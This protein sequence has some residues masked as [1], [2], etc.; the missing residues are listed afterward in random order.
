VARMIPP[1]VPEECRSPGE[2]EIFARLQDDPATSD[3][4]VLH[5]LDVA[6]H[7]R[8]VAGEIDFVIVVPEKGVLCLEV[9]ACRELHRQGGLWYY[10]P[11]SSTE[12][13]ARGPFRQVADT[14]HSLR[15]RLVKRAPGLANVVFWSGVVFPYVNF[16]VS[17]E[18]WHE[19]QV[20]DA[21]LFKSHPFALLV[22]NMLDRAREHLVNAETAKWFDARSRSPDSLQAETL[23]QMLRPHFEFFQSPKARIQQLDDE[24]NRYT[25]EQLEAL[26]A[27]EANS[28]VLFEGPAGTGK[29]MLAIE[30][31]RRGAA[32]GRRV[33]FVCFNRLLAR[34]L[35]VDIASMPSVKVCT[36]HRHML[37]VVGQE[38]PPADASE[39]F[40]TDQLPE[41][42]IATVLGSSEDRAYDQVVVDEAQDILRRQYLDF[43]DLSIT[44]GLAAGRWRFFGDFERQAIYGM[45]Q[46]SLNGLLRERA[47]SVAQYSLRVNCRN[48]P[49]ISELAQ[50][51][52][53]MTP[54][55]RHVLRPDDGIDPV[56]LFYSGS[57][58][59]TQK[60]LSSLEDLYAE[61]FRG[62]DI[63]ILSPRA[64]GACASTVR[65][66]AWKDRLRPLS[67]DASSGIS[68]GSI[69]A[70]KGLESRAIVVTDIDRIGDPASQALFYVATTRA[71]HRLIILAHEAVR[72]E[73]RS[74]VKRQLQRGER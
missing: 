11:V 21:R 41:H 64:Q 44:G 28:R 57:S 24:V 58:D 66:P 53:G 5:S 71:L 27:M 52:G 1:V 54:P 42:A 50:L 3:W 25:Q 6:R 22:R 40:W 68:Y 18:E 62:S 51:L 38:G 31:A 29:T 39:S 35:A 59:Q 47:S 12:G 46:G 33:L 74:I 67:I 36:L 8:Q 45:D 4:F 69:H 19:W 37:D 55:Y 43:L 49:R 15:E 20:I 7:L 34:K 14:M 2:K 61:G 73:A 9:K 26:D 72:E 48:T 13:D 56:L 30:A 60:L 10:G 17:S 23:V 70:F 65:H 63:T 32:S 16:A